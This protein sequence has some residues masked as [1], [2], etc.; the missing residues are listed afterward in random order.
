M[1][2]TPAPAFEPVTIEVDGVRTAVIDTGSRDRDPPPLL[3]L[4]HGSGPGVSATANWRLVVPG[5]ASSR[6]VIAPDQLGFGGTATGEARQFGRQAWTRHA[7][8]LLDR[9]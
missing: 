8:A 4:L 3:L 2:T 7:I 5:L 1:T 6:R 9:L